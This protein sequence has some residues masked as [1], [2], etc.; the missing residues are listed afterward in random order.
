MILTQISRYFQNLP[1]I[2]RIYRSLIIGGIIY[3]IVWGITLWKISNS[4]L[5]RAVMAFSLVDLV[6]M[7]YQNV[8]EY[9]Y[10]QP[11]LPN[12]P[13]PQ[14]PPELDLDHHM[15]PGRGRLFGNPQEVLNPEPQRKAERDQAERDQAEHGQAEHDQAEQG[16]ESFDPELPDE[17]SLNLDSINDLLEDDSVLPPPDDDVGLDV[18]SV[19]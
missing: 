4:W 9:V 19:E 8:S 15:D 10:D 7:I 12:H 1:P 11:E 6:Y 5:R 3:G 16:D 2:S 13:H 18:E 17:D 14:R